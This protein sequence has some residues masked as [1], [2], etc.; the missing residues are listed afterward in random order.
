L[1][2]IANDWLRPLGEVVLLVGAALVGCRFPFA[3][4]GWLEAVFA[5]LTVFL[6][7]GFSFLG[8]RLLWSYFGIFLS[9]MGIFS[10]VARTIE[11]KGGLP[12]P[13]ALLGT[14]LFY[15]YEA[16][17]FTLVL[18]AARWA[19]KRTGKA[20]AAGITAGFAL[21]LWEIHGFHV[22]Q[23]GWGPT[24]AGLPFLA[25][26]AAFITTYGLSALVWGCAAATASL[27]AS[28]RSWRSALVPPVLGLGLL[29]FLAGAWYLLPRGP[30]RELDV[31]MI[32]P[33]FEPG[34]RRPGMEE[35]LW[36][37]SDRI[38][39]GRGL[40]RKGVT[41]LLLWPESAILGRNDLLPNPRHRE[42]ARKRD[43]AW[44]FGTEGGE[45]GWNHLSYNLVRGESPS[46]PSFVQAKTEPMPFGERMP[47]P[48]WLRAWLDTQLGFASAV[49]GQLSAASAFEVATPQGLLRIHPLICSEALSASRVQDGAALT[50]AEL[51][52]NHTNDGWFDESV[53]TDLH[54]VQIRLRAVEMGVPLL[55]STLT[56]KSGVFREDGTW[57][58]WG[59]PLTETD[60]AFTLK[61]RPIR[62][63]ARSP[64][65]RY[66]LLGMLGLGTLLL[67]W[68]GRTTETRP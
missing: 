48:P 62:T 66:G 68:R 65:I 28:G 43:V 3:G 36:V 54:A 12:Y 58:L 17:G 8:R 59:A 56:G 30:E 21:L 53:A 67:A 41:T 7:M 55:R 5:S 14:S 1:K 64:W 23:C 40:P 39:S 61:W 15:L 19:H 51:L 24:L 34:L 29:T 52:T 47:G 31:V 46:G 18:V 38:L 60:H 35:E 22:Y 20:W 50:G 26:G 57:T 27:L 33:N 16:A 4:L 9:L 37:R 44:L 6:F 2:G 11:T 49:P 25:K 10:W 32:Q 63:P 45:R 13:L 42:E